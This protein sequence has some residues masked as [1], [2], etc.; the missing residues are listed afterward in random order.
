MIRTGITLAEALMEFYRQHDLGGDGGAGRRWVPIMVGPLRL[1]FPNFDSRRR[2]LALHD[3]HHILTGYQAGWVGE[4]EIGGWEVAGG[5]ANYGAAWVFNLWS[6][7]VGVFRCPRRLFRAFVRGRHSS[8]LYGE[9][10]RDALLK[11][12]VGAA[13]ERLRLSGAIPS[14]DAD[15]ILAFAG[16]TAVALLWLVLPP[17]TIVSLVRAGA[18][19]LGGAP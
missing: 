4:A 8:N 3:L 17:A 2:A 1:G 12:T 18:A 13:R 9:G 15:D 14:P 16:W 7:G 11:E 6:F 19:F 10:L 5:C